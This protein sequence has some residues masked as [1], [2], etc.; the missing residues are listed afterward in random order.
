[1]AL[2]RSTLRPVHISLTRCRHASVGSVGAWER[3]FIRDLAAPGG[4]FAIAA[5]SIVAVFSWPSTVFT[6][7]AA[8]T[9]ENASHADR[10][11]VRESRAT[12]GR[13]WRARR[14][15]ISAELLGVVP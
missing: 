6:R 7:S 5:E 1:M 9:P 12:E 8:E 13:R 14:G 11:E 10:R 4:G 2:R 15:C 3:N